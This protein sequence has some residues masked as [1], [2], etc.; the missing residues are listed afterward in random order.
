MIVAYVDPIL[1]LERD[2]LIVACEYRVSNSGTETVMKIGLPDGYSAEPY[3]E[4]E[5]KDKAKDKKTSSKKSTSTA[6]K[7]RAQGK[8]AWSD[9]AG[10]DEVDE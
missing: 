2:M 1:G 9:V 5:T 8:G 6:R 4:K 7:G 10:I 3:V